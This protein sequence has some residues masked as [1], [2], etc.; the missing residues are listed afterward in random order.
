MSSTRKLNSDQL[1]KKGESRFPEICVDAGLT[2]N[3]AS[4]DRRGWDFI[5]DWP[6]ESG[7]RALD[8]RPAPL[9]CLVQV[10]T[11]WST[12]KAVTLRLSSA[13]FIAKDSR[14]TFIYVLRVRDDLT[15]VDARIAHLEGDLLALVL[16]EL[17]KARIADAEPNDV[18]I[19]LSLGR[20]FGTLPL[21][22]PSLRSEIERF[23][24][25]SPIDYHNR[26]QRQLRE[27]GYEEG[28]PF[29]TTTFKSQD[30]EH[31]AE[32]FLG[33]RPIEMLNSSA[34]DRRFDLD[35]PI[36]ELSVTSAIAE[37][38]PK[39]R[40]SCRIAA[41]PESGT[42]T[43]NFKGKVYGIPAALIPVGELRMLIRTELFDLLL[44]GRI[45][46]AGRS[47]LTLTIRTEYDRIAA[48]RA[49]A[50]DWADFYGF[51]AAL[52][53]EPVQ[54][55][56]K[57]KKIPEPLIGLASVD[58][59]ELASGWSRPARLTR[60]ASDVLSRAGWPGTRLLIQEIGDAG[61]DLE[62][63]SAMIYDP[64]VLTR[65][66]IETEIIPQAR[67]GDEFDMIFMDRFRLG[68]H[69]IAYA[70]E[71]RLTA[72]QSDGRIIWTGGVPRFRDL[73]RIG[74]SKEDYAR[75]VE[76]VRTGSGRQSY[77]AAH[78]DEFALQPSKAS[79]LPQASDAGEIGE[80]P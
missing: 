65:L 52:G 36:P 72:K 69:S 41:R 33:L 26:K 12:S 39:P 55:S 13:E 19:R 61:D 38:T 32:A 62:I 48:I 28:G 7:M 16:R 31:I 6:H 2:P 35:I 78:W 63:L 34:V 3:A 10:K 27:L 76:K 50:E 77:Y 4:W 58:M 5:V 43:F 22:G 68:R 23:V 17:R 20:W 57:M 44:R 11:V 79:D 80:A 46:D 75:Y 37:I 49:R 18:E 64:T 24:G 45:P 14:P 30:M 1:G 66:S 59:E 74:P 60:I 29:L 54:L 53:N 25:A 56:M 71:V 47:T 73:K 21:D 9:S 67:T 40:D 51:V 8:S 70:A 15:F 42:E